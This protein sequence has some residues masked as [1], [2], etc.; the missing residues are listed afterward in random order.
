ME[1]S[2]SRISDLNSRNTENHWFVTASFCFAIA[3]LNIILSPQHGTRKGVLILRRSGSSPESQQ[4]T[5]TCGARQ[6]GL[7]LQILQQKAQVR[8]CLLHSLE[9]FYQTLSSQGLL[10]RHSVQQVFYC[11]LG[12][13]SLTAIQNHLRWQAINQTPVT[14]NSKCIW[15]STGKHCKMALQDALSPASPPLVSSVTFFLVSSL[16]CFNKNLKHFPNK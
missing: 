1:K 14:G 7:F 15:D 8:E 12:C 10:F 2:N 9:E 6:S 5:N 3:F 16:V 11:L 4:L 13:S